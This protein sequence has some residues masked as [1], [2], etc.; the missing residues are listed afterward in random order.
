MT[1]KPT[2]IIKIQEQTPEIPIEIGELRFAFSLTDEN[3]LRFRRDGQAIADKIQ[4][5]AIQ[6]T[7]SDEVTIEKIKE[8]LATGF[9]F[10]LGEGAFEKIYE[11]TPSISFLVSYFTQLSAGISKELD[12]QGVPNNKSNRYTRRGKQKQRQNAQNK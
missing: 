8:V 3:I 7:D 9:D 10:M 4:V 12:N 6:D 11:R 5:I 1:N 2:N